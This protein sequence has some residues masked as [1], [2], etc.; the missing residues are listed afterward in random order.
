MARGL[1][2]LLVPCLLV[3]CGDRVSSTSCLDRV[4]PR[5]SG[6][7]ARLQFGDTEDGYAR[8]E[9]RYP[10][11]HVFSSIGPPR[12]IV[13]TLP[14]L[15]EIVA[16]LDGTERIVGVTPWCDHPV[17][18]QDGRTQ[19]SVMPL[20]LERLIALRPDLL[21][22][23]Q[24]LLKG[25]MDV[26]ARRFPR[27]LLPLETSRSLAHLETSLEIVAAVL[28]TPQAAARLRTWKARRARLEGSVPTG[29]TPPRV[30]IVSGWKPLNVIGAHGLMNDLL[31]A[32][33]AVN[34]ACDLDLP[35]GTFH[36]ELVLE[37]RPDF[38][39]HRT[40]PPPD[41]VAK[42]WARLPAFVEG[43]VGDCESNDLARGGPRILDALERL[44]RVLRE[45]APISTLRAP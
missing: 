18:I 42:R 31:R 44:R 26:L 15:T 9:V 28:D 37:R 22:V 8:V 33:G 5:P 16:W 39:L 38:V 24:T 3:A 10:D 12:R 35:S 13:C 23:D 19:V 36:E 43:R 6:E 7:F 30:L 14:G 40:G 29:K 4:A 1:A 20:D 25:D 41:F 21:L 34:V 2:L 45:D 27:A 11:G 32:C 17:G